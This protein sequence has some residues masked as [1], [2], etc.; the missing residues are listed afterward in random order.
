MYITVNYCRWSLETTL[1]LAWTYRLELETPCE[2]N[3]LH[4]TLQMC[5]ALLTVL[6]QNLRLFL[7]CNPRSVIQ[8]LFLP[9]SHSS[10]CTLLF[11]FFFVQVCETCLLFFHRQMLQIFAGSF[12]IQ[13]CYYICTCQGYKTIGHFGWRRS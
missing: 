1:H 8:T 3:I 5:V 4:V 2:L 6:A 12:P 11:A 13:L 10:P 9:L 7:P